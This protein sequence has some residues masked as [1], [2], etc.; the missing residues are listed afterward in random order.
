MTMPGLPEIKYYLAVAENTVQKEDRIWSTPIP[1]RREHSPANGGSVLS[2]GDYFLG[3]LKFLKKNRFKI[4]AAA[5]SQHQGRDV[6]YEEID[7]I[8]IFLEKHGEFY[9]P[10][11]IEADLQGLT[12]LFVV[13]VAVS[14][15][16]KSRIQK[17]YRF[18]QK[19]NI[20]FPFDF[21]PK[22][23]GLDRVFIKD[24][25][26]EI[27]LFL[28]EWFEGFC[29]FHVS[30]DPLDKTLKI[31]VWDPQHGNRSLTID[32]SGALYRQM[33]MILTSYYNVETFEQISLW[34]HA[35]GDFVIRC[36]NDKIDVKL[37]TVRQYGPMFAGDASKE[38]ETHGQNPLKILEALLVF[39]LNLAIRMRLDRL[40]GVG[41]IVWSDRVAVRQ[42]LQGVLDALALK[43]PVGRFKKPLA[44]AFREHLR[45]CT[46]TELS[47]L[48][49]ALVDTYHPRSPDVPVIKN[50]LK[51]HIDDLY[52]A[53]HWSGKFL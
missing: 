33:A 11:R 41:E 5:L 51:Q 23:Y 15:V 30:C 7:E 49:Q 39:F 53:I 42:T 1:M 44:D 35:A 43:P 13:N 45:S 29:E 22:V 12:V 47:D 21:L 18:L 34:H 19:L 10:A 16:G 37:I 38:I 46:R 36:Q 27:R 14:H 17:E 20:D 31:V 32:Q 9:H 48:N 8:R 50:H 4:L 26:L 52:C 2:H 6:T 40:D 24:D 28:G 25:T 3:V